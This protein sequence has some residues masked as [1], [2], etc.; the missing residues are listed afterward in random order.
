MPSCAAAIAFS[1]IVRQHYHLV[2]MQQEQLTFICHYV[3]ILNKVL[4]GR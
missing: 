3:G 1:A 2:A 4:S